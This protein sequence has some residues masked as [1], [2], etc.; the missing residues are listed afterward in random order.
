M[1]GNAAEWVNSFYQAYPGNTTQDSNFGNKYRVVR[2]GS[3]KSEIADGRT[4]FRDYQNPDV[5][6]RVTNGKEQLT[7]VGFR[8]AISA[9][10]PRLLQR[11]R[12]RSP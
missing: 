6:E 4:T 10:D 1:A 7:A 8:C 3:Y 11:L 2:G 12:T 5:E 9:D